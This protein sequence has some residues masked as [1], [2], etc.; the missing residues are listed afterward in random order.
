MMLFCETCGNDLVSRM[1][2]RC[3]YNFLSITCLINH[4]FVINWL[5]YSRDLC[6]ATVTHLN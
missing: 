6:E 5:N 4:F 2:Q 1:A 3:V